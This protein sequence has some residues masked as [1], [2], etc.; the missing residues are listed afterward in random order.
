MNQHFSFY[1]VKMIRKG[2]KP[3]IWRRGVVPQYVT[4]SQM[5]LGLI[6][7][8]EIPVT[9]AIASEFRYKKP[10]IT[11]HTMVIAVS[12]SGETTDTLEALKLAKTKTKKAAAG[13]KPGRKP[14]SKKTA[15]KK[16]A[17]AKK[18]GRKPASEKTAA[19]KTVSKKTAAKA[20][21]KKS[22][23]RKTAGRKPAAKT[24]TK[25]TGTYGTCYEVH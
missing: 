4:F 23:A 13:K 11:D 2:A 15:S 18:P 6:E 24:A 16:T 10:V 8:L 1:Q 19:G 5:A 14:A 20:A 9:V 12:Q 21:A 25:G 22:V 17:A 7:L 3:P